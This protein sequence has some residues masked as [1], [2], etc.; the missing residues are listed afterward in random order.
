[1]FA[2]LLS[3]LLGAAPAW[4]TTGGPDAGG[5]TFIDSNEPG[6]PVYIWEDISVTGNSLFLGDDDA[7]AVPIGFGFPFYSR[8]FNQVSVH[9]NGLL[10]FH[11]PSVTWVSNSCVSAATAYDSD[12][13]I[14]VLWDDLNPSVGGDVQWELRGVAPERRLIVTWR[15]VPLYAASTTLHS[16]QAVLFETGVIEFR[17]RRLDGNA[18]FATIGIQDAA[19]VGL[20]YRCNG[21]AVAASTLVRFSNCDA[22]LDFDGDGVAEC[23]D[24]D[25]N[26]A[27]RYPTAPESCDGV[28]SDCDGEDGADVDGDGYDQCG[29]D[30]NDNNAAINPGATEQPCNGVDDDCGANTPDSVDGDS[31]GSSSCDDC[32]DNNPQRSPTFNEVGCNSI[33]DDCDSNT[34]DRG[35]NDGDGYSVCGEDCDDSNPDVSPAATEVRCNVIDDDCDPGTLDSADRDDD[36]VSACDD[37]DDLDPDV[38]PGLPDVCDELDNDCDE[39]IDEDC[40]PEA[41]GET[42]AAGGPGGPGGP[43]GTDAE[44]T[45]WTGVIGADPNLPFGSLGCASAAGR[46]G[47]W[48]AL[49]LAVGWRRRA[50]GRSER[51]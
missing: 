39:L 16:F 26:N 44:D 6:G 31:D 25:D 10:H 18:S 5:Y 22:A 43:G 15:L 14:A 17:F 2:L 9:S 37:C 49:L 12:R 11:A 24:C 40:D 23:S 19:G 20:Q 45:D 42:D 41:P 35:D 33:D 51:R 1:V 3:A 48:W 30:C 47:A 8:S 29:S 36:G 50:G 7:I 4:A 34:R 21:S 32:D 28:D 13:F 46:G 27:A 38:A